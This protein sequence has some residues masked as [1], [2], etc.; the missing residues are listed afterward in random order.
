ML[1]RALVGGSVATALFFGATVAFESFSIIGTVFYGVV[2]TCFF[3]LWPTFRR[4]ATRSANP[5]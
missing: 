2:M 3:A 4:S 5:S 1:L